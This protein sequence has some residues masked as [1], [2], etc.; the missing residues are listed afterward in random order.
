MSG[1]NKVVDTYDQALRGIKD[2]MLLMVG[3]FGL[4]G[5]PEGLIQK[6]ADL[7]VKNLTCI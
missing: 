2:D 6:V 3:G 4:C 7:G 1:L 5:I